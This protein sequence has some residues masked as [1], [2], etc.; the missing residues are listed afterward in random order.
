MTS[1]IVTPRTA[2][3]PCSPSTQ[4]MAST[5]LLLP[6]PLGPTTQVRPGSKCRV[7]ALAKDLNPR[8][9]NRS[10]CTRLPG[11]ENYRR[12]QVISVGTGPRRRLA[13]HISAG[14]SA[15]GAPTVVEARQ[16]K[17]ALHLWRRP[18]DEQPAR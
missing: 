3:A 15:R 16:H 6:E 18:F 14:R 9:V 5:T 13:A 11:A 12:P 4:A 10:R 2:F 7:V 17:G 1:D 8:R